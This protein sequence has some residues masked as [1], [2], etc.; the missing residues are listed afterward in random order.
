MTKQDNIEHL[1]NMRKTSFG[2]AIAAI[3]LLTSLV[4]YGCKKDEDVAAEVT[5]GTIYGTVT[6]FATGDPIGNVNVKLSPSGTT[7]LTGSNGMFQFNELKADSY[8]LSFSKAGYND[9]DDDYVIKLESGRKLQRDVQMQ[10]KNE[11]E[12]YESFKVLYNGR[13]VDTIE[14]GHRHAFSINVVNDGT[15]RI[16]ID[17]IITIGLFYWNGNDVNDHGYLYPGDGCSWGVGIDEEGPWHEGENIE[18]IYVNSSQVSK[19]IVI[20]VYM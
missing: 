2:V 8:S 12:S 10:R 1:Q 14:L 15:L 6:D 20:K 17:A 13:E 5:T 7:T 16:D 19:M 9:L 11:E 4:W 18:V 3:V